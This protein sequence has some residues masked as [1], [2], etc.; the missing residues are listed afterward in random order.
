VNG[1]LAKIP[2]IGVGPILVISAIAVFFLVIG[3][4]AWR[5][6]KVLSVLLVLLFVVVGLGAVADWFN[7]QKAYYDTAADLFGIPTYPVSDGAPISGPSAQPQPDGTV[8]TIQIPDTQSHFGAFDAKVWLPPQYFTDTRAHFPVMLL[9]AGN[10]GLNT[11]WLT[12]ASAA[13]TGLAV[14][15]SG[16]PVILV[17]PTVLRDRAFGDSL[18]LDTASQGN[19]ETYVVKDVVAAVDDQ[20]RTKVDPKQRGIGGL[21]MGGYCALNLGLKHPDVFSTVLDFSG[22]TEPVVDTLPG[23]LPDLFGPNYQPA[24]DANTP[25]KY[26]STLNPARGPAIWMD[27]GAS[28]AGSMKQMST[29]VPLLKAKGFTVEFHTRP[30]EHDFKTFGNGLADALPWAAGRFYSSP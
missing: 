20:L 13:S 16:K 19:V 29:L 17:M 24:V 9:I 10:P 11:D 26:L 14:A 8:T 15:K 25:A 27:V 2:L 3:V 21:S 30:G 1:L 4:M 5:R 22:D 12:S 7:T 18:C 23:G 28:D 6:S